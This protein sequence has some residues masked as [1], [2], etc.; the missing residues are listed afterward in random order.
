M[1]SRTNQ[2]RILPSTFWIRFGKLCT[3]LPIKR[4]VQP[5]M[6][7]TEVST[8]LGKHE[9]STQRPSSTFAMASKP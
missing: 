3:T 9:S 7:T 8:T 1:S 6:C 2:S 4:Q 5:V